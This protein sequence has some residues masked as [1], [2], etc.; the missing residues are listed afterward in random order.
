MATINKKTVS[1]APASTAETENKTAAQSSTSTADAAMVYATTLLVGTVLGI[2]FTK[3][4]VVRWQRINEMF[5]FQDSHLYL[6]IGSAVTVAM[7]GMFLIRKCKASDIYGKPIRY[8]PKPFHKGVI[9]GGT[10]FGAGWAIAGACPG[11]IYAQ[12]G[13]GVGP[14]SF[15]CVGALAGMYLYALTKPHLP[16]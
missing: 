3:S 5:L 10:A 11:T 1:P 7:L 14:A 6:I 8:S 9:L 12:L 2:L 13:S 16:H 4:E 15:T